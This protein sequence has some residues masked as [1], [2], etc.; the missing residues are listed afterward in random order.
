MAALIEPKGGGHSLTVEPI[1]GPAC[2]VQHLPRS[3]ALGCG[4]VPAAVTE[5]LATTYATAH[6]RRTTPQANPAASTTGAH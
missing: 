1:L 6:A 2:G 3:L 4:Y 5:Y